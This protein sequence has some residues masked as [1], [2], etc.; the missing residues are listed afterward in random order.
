MTSEGFYVVLSSTSTSYNS[1]NRPGNYRVDLPAQLN[2]GGPWKVTLMAISF[3]AV[4][5]PKSQ[6]DEVV[7]NM[8]GTAYRPVKLTDFFETVGELFQAVKK[9]PWT[10]NP[11]QKHM[12]VSAK[13]NFV[14]VTTDGN[15]TFEFS[16]HLV[17]TLGLVTINGSSYLRYDKKLQQEGVLVFIKPGVTFC[18]CEQGVSNGCR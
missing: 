17:H 10:K 7:F 5:K 4:L 18:K 12:K 6:P 9:K 3:P 1:K 11:Y 15:S 16:F 13:E 8:D 2:F 14:S